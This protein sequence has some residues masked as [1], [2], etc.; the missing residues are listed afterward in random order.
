MFGLTPIVT[1][2]AKS[3]RIVHYDHGNHSRRL[4]STATPLPTYRLPAWPGQSAVSQPGNGR[5]EDITVS[6]GVAIPDA[7]AVG[8]TFAAT[9][10]TTATPTFLITT[11]VRHGNRL[12]ENEGGISGDITKSAWVSA[13]WVICRARCSSTTTRTAS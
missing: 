6:A 11:I 7:I 13:T 4:T 2:P 10:I 12:F 8:A 9:S 3:T 1:T 5:F